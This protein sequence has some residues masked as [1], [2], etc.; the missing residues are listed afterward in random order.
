[1]FIAGA[2]GGAVVI[3]VA[4]YD[5]HSRYSRYSDA[6]ERERRSRQERLNLK[7]AA[8]TKEIEREKDNLNKRVQEAITA[9][10]SDEVLLKVYNI[11]KADNNDL[12]YAKEMI[13]KPT[14]VQKQLLKNLQNEIEEKLEN[15]KKQLADIDAAI[16]NINKLQLSYKDKN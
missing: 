14:A 2:I 15:D 4:S 11:T 10:K 3:G 12:E 7:I 13:D 8:K 16:M 9:F 6:A 1:M 5:D